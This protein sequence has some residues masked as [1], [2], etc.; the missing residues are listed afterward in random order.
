MAWP[1]MS[2]V[3]RPAINPNT[4]RAMASGLMA[5]S[6]LASVTDVT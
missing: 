2:S 3:A 1:A 5:R 4:P 6:A